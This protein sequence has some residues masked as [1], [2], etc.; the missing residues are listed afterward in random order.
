MKFEPL[1]PI[2]DVAR[3]AGISTERVRQLD[4]ELKP[5]RLPNGHRRYR[6]SAVE[7]LIAK[8]EKAA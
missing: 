6:A 5:V 7:A 2:A 1:M 3:A 4:D 8:R